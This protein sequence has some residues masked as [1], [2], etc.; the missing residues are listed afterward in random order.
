MEE[1]LS[2][3][4]A[5]KTVI[6]LFNAIVL[7]DP[8]AFLSEIQK[9][10]GLI[11]VIPGFDSLTARFSV[12]GTKLKKDE[13]F[14]TPDSK[15]MANC[16]AEIP[17]YLLQIPF[18]KL[19]KRFVTYSITRVGKVSCTKKTVYFLIAHPGSSTNGRF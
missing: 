5:Q 17:S 18:F 19:R 8:K 3:D 4:S 10:P 2:L 12:C 11:D 14:G 16:V 9:K 15:M 6:P 1:G 7:T 13:F